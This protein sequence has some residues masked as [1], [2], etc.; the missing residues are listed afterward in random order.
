MQSIAVFCGS[1]SGI[2]PIYSEVSAQLGKLLAQEGI[3]MIYGAGNVGLM[4]VIADACLD[5][6]GQV[7]GTIPQFLKDMEVAHGG[8]TKLFVTETMHQRKEKMADIAQGIIILPGGIGTMDEFFEIFTWQQLGLHSNSIGIL[9]ING[10]YD[11]LLKH[12]DKMTE[13]GFLKPFH[14]ERILVSDDPQA[15]L[16]MMKVQKIEYVDKWWVNKD[17]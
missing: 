16:E 10:F 6:G 2:N 5:E 11:H 7:I 15:L 8:L 14:K 9:N 3:S 17:E 13:E 12:L 1:S 4:G